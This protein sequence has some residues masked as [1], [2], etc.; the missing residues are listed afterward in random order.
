MAMFTTSDGADIRYELRGDG[1]AVVVCHGGPNNICDTIMRDIAPLSDSYELVFHD[2]RG[3]GGSASAPTDS[4]TFDRLADDIDELVDHLE[5]PSVSVVAHSMGGLV[6]LHYALRH[7]YRCHR[8]ALVATTPCG[9]GRTMAIP[10]LRALGPLRTAKA[11]ALAVRYAAGW[12]WRPPS[13]ER[14]K[15][16]YAPWSVTQEPRLELRATVAGAHPEL[17][18]D[19]DNAPHLMKAMGALDLR[20]QLGNIRSPALVLYGS[21]DAAMVAGGRMLASGLPNADLRVLSDVGHEVFVEAP[22]ETF[23][24]LLRFLVSG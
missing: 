10:L 20:G 19:N 23:D 22:T 8:L 21:R 6:A 15:A 13:Q 11:L 17:P 1:P 4:Y 14:T 16:M 7:P 3:S 9:V 18:V 2:Y 5:H 12:S 24:A